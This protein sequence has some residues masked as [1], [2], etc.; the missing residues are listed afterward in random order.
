MK[1]EIKSKEYTNA[2]VGRTWSAKVV[3]KNDGQMPN[4]FIMGMTNQSTEF[5]SD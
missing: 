5:N 2:R 4:N 3:E 1:K